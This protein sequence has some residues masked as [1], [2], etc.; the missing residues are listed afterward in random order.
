M[1]THDD[2]LQSYFQQL[3]E[4]Y[5]LVDDRDI[6]GPMKGSRVHDG[7][8]RYLYVH[9]R[10]KSVTPGTGAQLFSRAENK[11]HKPSKKPDKDIKLI[12]FTK[13]HR[14]AMVLGEP[15]SGK[16]TLLRYL[17]LKCIN[18]PVLPAVAESP[19]LFDEGVS[20]IPVVVELAKLPE[21]RKSE[22]PLSIETIVKTH[23][24]R[25]LN[26]QL[27]DDVW[28]VV[29]A[30]FRTGTTLLL[31]D[32]LDEVN[33]RRVAIARELDDFVRRH[34]KARVFI[35]AR[36]HAEVEM[37]GFP[38]FIIKKFSSREIREFL[39]RRAR[40]RLS[41]SPET[42][43]WANDPGDELYER[44]VRSEYMGE[45]A[46]TPLMLV[47]MSLA[48]STQQGCLP[49]RRI[50]LYKTIVQT[51]LKTPR[52]SAT[53]IKIDN[54]TV[55]ELWCQAALDLA[56]QGI[57]GSMH[58]GATLR[59]VLTARLAREPSGSNNLRMADTLLAIA[60]RER[61]L[62]H[63]TEAH[64][65]YQFWHLTIAE[66]MAAWATARDV[67]HLADNLTALRDSPQDTRELLRMVLEILLVEQQNSDAFTEA[68]NAIAFTRV[69]CW[70][71]VTQDNLRLASALLRQCSDVKP[72]C[73]ENVLAALAEQVCTLPDRSLAYSF[74]ELARHLPVNGSPS[75]RLVDA[76]RQVIELP[77]SKAQTSELE[78]AIRH[79]LPACRDPKIRELF[80][81][82]IAD[83]KWGRGWGWT[84]SVPRLY[85][86]LGLIVAGDTRPSLFSQLAKSLDSG[87][88]SR[89][90][91]RRMNSRHDDPRTDLVR[92]AERALSRLDLD[93]LRLEAELAREDVIFV[94]TLAGRDTDDIFEWLWAARQGRET[95][96]RAKRALTHLALLDTTVWKRLLPFAFA[97]CDMPDNQSSSDARTFLNVVFQDSNA[98]RRSEILNKIFEL[99]PA[100]EKRGRND[101]V[102]L[103]GQ[104]GCEQST[105]AL[106]FEYVQRALSGQTTAPLLLV[107]IVG[108][109]DRHK[110]QPLWRQFL[111]HELPQVRVSAAG[112]LV[113]Q[114]KHELRGKALDTLV[115]MAREEVLH[116]MPTQAPLEM[117]VQAPVTTKT[118]WSLEYMWGHSDEWLLPLL[119]AYHNREAN[120]TLR[121]LFACALVKRDAKLVTK[122]MGSLRE[123]LDSP[124]I[125]LKRR[126][127]ELL[128]D[129]V[130]EGEPGAPSRT[131]LQTSLLECCAVPDFD[132]YTYDY[133]LLRRL[134][135][136]LPLGPQTGRLAIIGCTKLLQVYPRLRPKSQPDAPHPILESQSLMLRA[137]ELL[138]SQDDELRAAAQRI[139]RDGRYTPRWRTKLVNELPNLGTTTA[140]E[141]AKVLLNSSIRNRI[142][143][144]TEA[145]LKVL[146]RV[147]REGNPAQQYEAIESLFQ[148]SSHEDRH[149]LVA[150]E[151]GD[152]KDPEHLLRVLKTVFK[153][154]SMNRWDCG[155][156]EVVQAVSRASGLSCTRLKAVAERCLTL[157]NSCDRLAAVSLCHMLESDSPQFLNAL[158]ALT[159]EGTEFATSKSFGFLHNAFRSEHLRTYF[160]CALSRHERSIASRVAQVAIL[161]QADVAGTMT[162]R[163]QS[164]LLDTLTRFPSGGDYPSAVVLWSAL[165]PHNW[166]PFLSAIN[167]VQREQQEYLIGRLM[168]SIDHTGLISGELVTWLLDYC[169]FNGCV[170]EPLN[171]ARC[172][173][174]FLEI[175]ETYNALRSGD[176]ATE[177]TCRKLVDE[178]A[179][180]H[181]RQ[182]L[183]EPHSKETHLRIAIALDTLGVLSPSDTAIADNVGDIL[184]A[185]QNAL[186]IPA[187]ALLKSLDQTLR[188]RLLPRFTRAAQHGPEVAL[189]TVLSAC[190]GDLFSEEVRNSLLNKLLTQN[191]E[192]E[193]RFSAAQRLLELEPTNERALESLRSLIL[194]HATDKYP[195]SS[196]A[197][198][199]LINLGYRQYGLH[200]YLGQLS[201]NKLVSA[202]IRLH[203]AYLL[204]VIYEA[205]TEVLTCTRQL[206][207]ECFRRHETNDRDFNA[208]VA[209]AYAAGEA[210]ELLIRSLLRAFS[211]HGTY[212]RRKLLAMLVL[213]QR[214]LSPLPLPQKP[215]T[216]VTWY[217]P[218]AHQADVLDSV[219]T[220]LKEE[221]LR[222]PDEKREA[223]R[224]LARLR[225][226]L[227]PEEVPDLLSE[228]LDIRLRSLEHALR[229]CSAASGDHDFLSAAVRSRPEDNSM[230][231]MAREWVY[232]R[233]DRQ[234]VHADTT[235]WHLTSPSFDAE[236]GPK[237][238]KALY[239]LLCELFE[240]TPEGLRRH[241][242]LHFDKDITR[243]LPSSS[244]S[245]ADLALAVQQAVQEK[246][247]LPQLLKTLA[248]ARPKRQAEVT[249]FAS[250]FLIQVDLSD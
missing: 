250:E 109:L 137:F 178:I 157:P 117:F 233:I 170:Y 92:Q 23:L 50:A 95:Q 115:N 80:A 100:D 241:M 53:P 91:G 41:E 171:V 97:R 79:V 60:A 168:E 199:M 118:L 138:E 132:M 6:R 33:E 126:A 54:D 46:K 244:A 191:S 94:Y 135:K 123:A 3:D 176:N 220:E 103:I 203:A 216:G 205:K 223:G 81:R 102:D 194:T 16:T 175:L 145:V 122:Y 195:T 144:E 74:V 211:L 131:E 163:L 67:E 31:L 235:A 82:K 30:G 108:K 38:C 231:Q 89:F 96:T 78:E 152:D 69:S 87:Y 113:R 59:S 101:V 212:H 90:E 34:P 7:T 8:L 222:L 177:V 45:L 156:D 165:S 112:K 160:R 4:A 189:W 105:R 2:P 52:V 12:E 243:G 76:L 249:K 32:A 55:F 98:G 129:A 187:Y 185:E 68:V 234:R 200:K 124:V 188:N 64:D 14:R 201:T 86:V 58:S 1:S 49:S 142:P 47:I 230:Q 61:G 236:H 136:T 20:L 164:E 134:Q 99:F 37:K 114:H 48:E 167:T 43:V 162:D 13:Q 25:F 214:G 9:P 5:Q 182:R 10:L 184:M 186:T 128:T 154:A 11:D 127:C 120:S 119:T 17:A 196:K 24:G 240:N 219:L 125:A 237:L 242:S 121:T 133:N 28:P 143:N 63:S 42:F 83:E 227:L 239:D 173:E 139:V 213:V 51:Q 210:R 19:A 181:L 221:L 15:G 104:F 93:S 35:S 228:A 193:V 206:L 172:L 70:E 161:L 183:S 44:I 146:W 130:L 174:P 26:R 180:P 71:K 18:S 77:A 150:G 192:P 158:Q 245:L 159:S 110:S 56:R 36:P 151:L 215:A 155:P 40:W 147:R 57:L 39:R 22:N 224:F 218:T 75:T 153:R 27:A 232:E 202:Q 197:A 225:P 107:E 217:P 166:M 247:R 66:Y 116:L 111:E 29:E 21:I 148:A 140:F 88:S 204:L 62:L 84:R 141:F 65:Q 179:A 169:I 198:R 229:R 72:G 190:N 106:I 226:E 248:R 85:M 238:K 246:G 73:G 149:R 207:D 208:A 209:L